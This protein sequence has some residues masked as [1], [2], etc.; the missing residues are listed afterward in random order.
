MGKQ[1]RAPQM[2][3]Y[4]T[5]EKGRYKKNKDS[6]PERAEFI[7]QKSH[8]RAII[9]REKGNCMLSHADQIRLHGEYKEQ[10]EEEISMIPSV[11]DLLEQPL[12]NETSKDEIMHEQVGQS[13][14][15]NSDENQIM[16]E[17]DLEYSSVRDRSRSPRE[18]NTGER[19]KE[20]KTIPKMKQSLEER[21]DLQGT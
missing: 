5:N 19:D 1:L 2:M 7:M 20:S 9:N 15:E 16:Q 6:N 17:D 11:N 18:R 14:F 4:S 12:Q 21:Q 10:N 3:T 13:E 8:N